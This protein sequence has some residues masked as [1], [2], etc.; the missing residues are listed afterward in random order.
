MAKVMALQKKRDPLIMAGTVAAVFSLV[1]RIPLLGSVGAEGVAYFAPVNE[2]FLLTIVFLGSGLCETMSQMMHYRIGRGQYRNAE[3]VFII[4]RNTA[5]I[6]CLLLALLILFGSRYIAAVIFLEDLSRMALLMIVPAII[7]MTFTCLLR[8]YFQGMGSGYPAAHSLILE[9]SFGIV[10][11]ILGAA[12]F[13]E[14]GQKVAAIMHNDSHAAAYGAFGAALGLAAAALIAFLHLLIIYI[15]YRRTEKSNIYRDNSRGRETPGYLYRSLLALAMPMGVY[16]V[17]AQL[18]PLLNQRIFYHFAQR[19]NDSGTAYI[20]MAAEWGN[21]YGIYLVVI[22][23][24]VAAVCMIFSKE[25]AEIAK[26]CIRGEQRP[27]QEQMQRTILYMLLA[28]VPVVIL[29]AVLAEALV[30]ALGAEDA[31]L[32]KG[33]L[34]MGSALVFLLAFSLFWMD[35]LKQFKRK[36]SIGLLT[37]GALCVQLGLL[38]LLLGKASSG[39]QMINLVVIS[40][41]AGAL[42]T[43]VGGFVI[44]HRIMGA[45]DWMKKCI[46]SLV[47][48]LLCGAVIGLM[49]LLLSAVLLDKLGAAATL[50]ICP[51]VMAPIYLLLMSV[52]RG[53]SAAEADNLPGG[54]YLVR[55][56]R[57]LRIW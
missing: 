12:Y 27:A 29:T 57:K 52:L 24:L 2:L 49:S 50:I 45:G 41:L 3:R 44:I 16:M 11:V 54:Q 23:I 51:I 47:V 18:G 36:H 35:L 48:S 46:R 53:L 13:H 28:T 22:G 21:Y 5:L 10:F 20:N 6:F 42:V 33:L 34:Q 17:M 7:L 56:G 4:S 43:F 15:M 38:Y 14:Y 1:V 26:T 19:M 39:G 30:G 25:S 37:A 40:N 8:G 9:K 32:S 31:A 55:I